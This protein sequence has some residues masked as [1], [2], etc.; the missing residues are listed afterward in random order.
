MQDKIV[1]HIDELFAE[2]DDGEEALRRAREDLG[3][4]RC[5]LLKAAVTGE[6]TADWRAANPPQESGADLL[7]RILSDRR[8]KW[9]T[10]PANRGKT[11]KEPA[12]PD[13]DGLPDLPEGWVWASIGQLFDVYVGATPSRSEPALWNGDIP[14]VSSGEVNFCRISA[15][16]ET[17]AKGALKGSTE[18]VHPPGTL[19]LGMIGEGKTRGQVAILDVAAAHN[20]NCASIRAS[21]TPIPPEFIY[22][23]LEERYEQTRAGSSG[24]N[25]PA[26]NKERIQSICVP[27]P[28]LSEIREIVSLI[29][30]QGDALGETGELIEENSSAAAFL[31]QSILAAA[32]RGELLP[33]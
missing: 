11:Y 32:F 26:L 7:A 13:T 5:A 16:R 21:L 15:T 9:R 27:L 3:R 8:A 30:A 33:A 17:I 1:D 29:D 18:R 10:N 31:R 28:P 2:I 25:Q 6:L 12:T 23:V 24:G 14:W 19:L 4:Y 20:Q 22:F